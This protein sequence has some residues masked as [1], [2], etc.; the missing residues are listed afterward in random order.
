MGESQETIIAG[1]DEAGRGPLAGP[2]VAAAVILPQNCSI[3]GITDSKKLTHKKREELFTVITKHAHV[4]IGIVSEK[5][6]DDINIL[7]ATF[8]AMRKAVINLT[9]K[10]TKL[11][12]DGN[13]VIP[14][15]KIAQEAIIKGDLKEQSIGA[16]SIIAKV[17]RDRILLDMHEQYPQYNFAKH[18]GYGTKEHR[19]AI[20]QHGPSPIHR[21]S[22]VVKPPPEIVQGELE[23]F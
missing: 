11:I 10:P 17:T 13:F 18:K 22:F 1:I 19:E 5:D 4:G 14:R 23:L 2:V 15:H 6:I 9:V 7:Q 20:L 12:I 8:K 3:D 16:A 21:R